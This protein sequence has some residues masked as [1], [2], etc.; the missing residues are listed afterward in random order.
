MWPR[1]LPSLAMLAAILVLPA[2]THGE[3]TDRLNAIIHG[4]AFGELGAHGQAVA[5]YLTAI[6]APSWRDAE[7]LLQR[8][9]HDYPDSAAVD[10]AHAFAGRHYRD[11]GDRPQAIAH[12]EQALS[13]AKERGRRWTGLLEDELTVLRGRVAQAPPG[14]GP[15]PDTD[16]WVAV[17]PQSALARWMSVQ[18][19]TVITPLLQE[20]AWSVVTQIGDPDQQALAGTLQMERAITAVAASVRVKAPPRVIFELRFTDV[21]G[22]MVAV[23]SR[24]AI[25]DEDGWRS[26]FVDFAQLPNVGTGDFVM[27]QLRF[28]TLCLDPPLPPEEASVEVAVGNLRLKTGD[29]VR[30]SDAPAG[31]AA[32]QP[33]G[34]SIL[35]DEE[36]CRWLPTGIQAQIDDTVAHEGASSVRVTADIDPGDPKR[37]GGTVAV[38]HGAGTSW[39]GDRLVFWCFPKTTAYLPVLIYDASGIQLVKVLDARSLTVGEWNRVEIV[40]AEAQR[41][42]GD[43]DTFGEIISVIFVPHAQWDG[44]RRYFRAPGEYVWY[45]DDLHVEGEGPVMLRRPAPAVRD[46]GLDMAWSTQAA[47]TVAPETKTTATGPGALRMEVGFTQDPDSGGE[48]RAVP[49]NGGAW[50]GTQI[51]FSCRAANVLLLAVTACDSDGTTVSWRLDQRDFA[52]GQW[53]TIELSPETQAN[54]GPGDERMDDIASLVFSCTRRS[55]FG[56]LQAVA[57]T[58]G[59]WYLDDFEIAGP[60]LP[61][62]PHPWGPRRDSQTL[63][64]DSGTPASWVPMG[65]LALD[66]DLVVVR[67]GAASVRLSLL[68]ERAGLHQAAQAQAKLDKPASVRGLRFW[69]YP[70]EASPVIVSLLDLDDRGLQGMVAQRM[71]NWLVTADNLVPSTWNEI[72][73][74]MADARMSPGPDGTVPPLP[75]VLDSADMLLLDVSSAVRERPQQGTWYIDSLELIAE[76]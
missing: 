3:T 17:T 8:I 63:R 68:P 33:R 29:P 12:F 59:T 43:G 9:W 37:A 26:F 32:L 13:A 53:R 15:A 30:T 20:G 6:Q 18:P 62:R 67:E 34:G 16:Q 71:A 41:G 72:I 25:P 46:I 69:L 35:T 39:L 61:V 65:R 57:G 31:D 36:G 40:L 70:R 2:L 10:V 55:D 51:R 58:T 7:P 74:S 14:P 56:G 42:G 22:T 28:L 44:P 66:R 27:G 64:D 24:E 76:E 52:P 38:A 75:Q 1:R 45:I 23:G 49:A 50:L 4:P 73:L 48:A 21:D 19:N 54:V 5:L 11:A 47:C 60:P